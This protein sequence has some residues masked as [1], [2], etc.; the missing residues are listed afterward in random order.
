MK[1]HDF[2][3]GNKTLVKALYSGLVIEVHSIIYT[4]LEMSIK[5]KAALRAQPGVAGGGEMKYYAHIV[6]S[7]EA[8][9]D[10]LVADIEKFSS[11]SEPDI[12]G[13]V[14]AL[15]NVIQIRLAN[16]QIVRLDK[17]GSYYPS[18]SSTASD[19]ATKINSANIRSVSVNYKA[20]KRILAKMKEA[21]FEKVSA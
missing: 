18:I 19:S 4:P 8:T 21:G 13:V 10:D 20:G 16:S 5:Y 11:L 1:V 2:N 9:V 15:E 17:L 3:P 6:F 12:K 14:I 7:G